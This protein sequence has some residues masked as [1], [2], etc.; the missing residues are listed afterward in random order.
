LGGDAGKKSDDLIYFLG[1]GEAEGDLP[2]SVAFWGDEN[3]ARFVFSVLQAVEWKWTPEQVLQQDS[4][5]LH[6]VL[7][8]S[9]VSG[10]LR[11]IKDKSK[12]ASE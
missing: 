8:I 7:M 10:T 11:R 3:E 4:A 9:G 5:L 6:D 1:S 2:D 12:N